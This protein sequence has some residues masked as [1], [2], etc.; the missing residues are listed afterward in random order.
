MKILKASEGK[1][2]AYKDRTGEEVKLGYVLY[3]G[4]NDDETRYYEVDNG[5]DNSI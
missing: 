4:V 2:F 1:I 3:L 5:E